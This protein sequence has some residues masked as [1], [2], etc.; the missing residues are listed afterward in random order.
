MTATP[1]AGA[2]RARLAQT[3]TPAVTFPG[4]CADR[5]GWCGHVDWVA[6]PVD[7]ALGDDLWRFGPAQPW[8]R[9]SHTRTPR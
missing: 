4:R 5:R 8:A 2:R 6:E 9:Q 7:A 3:P 1:A